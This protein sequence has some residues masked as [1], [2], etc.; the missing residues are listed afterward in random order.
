MSNWNSVSTIKPYDI[1][2]YQQLMFIFFDK[3]LEHPNHKNV[4]EALAGTDI[5][6]RKVPVSDYVLS[7]DQIDNTQL[8]DVQVTFGDWKFEFRM[9]P[10]WGQYLTGTHRDRIQVMSWWK[11]DW[12]S[13]VTADVNLTTKEFDDQHNYRERSLCHKL[14]YKIRN[15]TQKVF[16]EVA[17]YL[18]KQAM[19]DNL[20][21]VLNIKPPRKRK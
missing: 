15:R 9:N 11:G 21:V 13:S 8:R 6:I 2:Q 20:K 14:T 17:K 1:W 16:N 4:M 18:E 12:I 10:F 5:D 7:Y 19:Y 3:L